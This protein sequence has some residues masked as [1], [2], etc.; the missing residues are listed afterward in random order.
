MNVQAPVASP[1]LPF[2]TYEVLTYVHRNSKALTANGF[3]TSI[4]LAGYYNMNGK[5]RCNPSLET[6]MAT[7]R[8]KSRQGQRNALAELE[9]VGEWVVIRSKGRQSNHYYPMFVRNARIDLL[10]DV[11]KRA[12][13]RKQDKASRMEQ[14]EARRIAE[15]SE[16]VETPEPI[17]DQSTPVESAQAIEVIEHIETPVVSSTPKVVT[18]RDQDILDAYLEVQEIKSADDYAWGI[19]LPKEGVIVNAID[20]AT[21]MLDYGN[22]EKLF[23]AGSEDR[24][25]DELAGTWIERFGAK[26]GPTVTYSV[27]HDVYDEL[28]NKA[29]KQPDFHQIDSAM[30]V[31][32]SRGIKP[33]A[34]FVKHILFN[35][36]ARKLTGDQPAIRQ[37]C[38]ATLAGRKKTVTLSEQ[39]FFGN[40]PPL[41]LN[42]T[43]DNSLKTVY[44][45]AL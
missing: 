16:T 32:G 10:S 23:V 34:G 44:V 12:E 11:A 29:D 42:A 37:A 31:L 8:I 39:N 30:Y 21:M 45:D 4:A 14:A 40:R 33:T 41:A 7:T 17:Q 5:E 27:I 35:P 20:D 38:A 6:L 43:T 3:N 2:T 15:A 36:D 13:E 18:Q 19:P 1:K 25:F 22:P 24:Y 26:F 9:A 28:L